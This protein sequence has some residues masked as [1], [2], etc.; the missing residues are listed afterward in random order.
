[1]WNPD[2]ISQN[3]LRDIV[4]YNN[5]CVGFDTEPARSISAPGF[6]LSE[7]MESSLP[8]CQVNRRGR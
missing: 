8:P 1:M 5:I 7:L 4:G 2:I 6:A 3:R